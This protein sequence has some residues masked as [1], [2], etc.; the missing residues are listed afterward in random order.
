M[1]LTRL[2]FCAFM[3]AV[4]ITRARMSS[5]FLQIF[6]ITKIAGQIPIEWNEPNFLRRY[7]IIVNIDG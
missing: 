4:V 2:E 3:V 7:T 5:T 1:W 6:I